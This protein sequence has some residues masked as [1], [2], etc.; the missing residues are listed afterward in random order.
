MRCFAS[1]LAACLAACL[2]FAALPA[3]AQAPA[4]AYSNLK[5]GCRAHV[6][7]DESGAGVSICPGRGGLLV[8]VSEDDIRQTVS[9]G[10]SEA[11]ARREPAAA[12]FFGPPSFAH[13]IVEW[14]SRGGRPFAAIQRWSI[15]EEGKNRISVLIVTRLPPGPV[16]HV[17]YIDARANAD[18]NA[19]ARE[20]AD[21]RAAGFDCTEKASFVGARG[22]GLPELQP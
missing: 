18:A 21:T 13:D 16:C 2:A 15:G 11:A 4:S 10:V 22:P 8:V 12:A 14:R 9:F 1:P 7:D 20:A 5:S 19:R 3:V 17:A 6:L